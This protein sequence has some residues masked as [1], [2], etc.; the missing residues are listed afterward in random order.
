[1]VSRYSFASLVVLLTFIATACW[2]RPDTYAYAPKSDGTIAGYR[3]SP[4]NGRIEPLPDK[5]AVMDPGLSSERLLL[6]THPSG[7]FLYVAPAFRADRDGYP[8]YAD[9]VPARKSTVVRVYRVGKDG[10]LTAIQ[11]LTVPAALGDLVM[12]PSGARLYAPTGLPAKK[13]NSGNR[14][15]LLRVLSDGRLRRE[16]YETTAWLGFS[17]VDTF[18]KNNWG[19]SFSPA[20]GYAYSYINAFAADWSDTRYYQYRTAG[21]GR[22][23]EE[24]INWRGFGEGTPASVAEDPGRFAG[25]SADGCTAFVRSGSTNRIW[26]CP[27][28]TQGR[29]QE[30]GAS[31]PFLSLKQLDS[32]GMTYWAAALY[33]HPTRPFV[34]HG[35]ADGKTVYT[36]Y[37]ITAPGRLKPIGTFRS[38]FAGGSTARYLTGEPTGRFL[39]EIG[40]DASSTTP[41]C[42]AV[43]KIGGDG[44]PK[45]LLPPT[46]LRM[47]G[48]GQL[49]FVA[50]S[51]Q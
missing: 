30:R 47:E 5:A 35:T 23:R 7:R 25:W 41:V 37:K 39:Y 31:P 4:I 32:P 1:M 6:T 44:I 12:H 50:P 8:L 19:L 24:P 49:L 18:Y 2:A 3:V 14:I 26:V 48:L 21:D 9:P 29:L 51:A 38:A 43:Y 40:Y 15:F 10:V 45:L 22:L 33:A 46:R 20:G 34:Y 17:Y 27:V 16:P 36:A 28:D 42:H 11:T 13:A